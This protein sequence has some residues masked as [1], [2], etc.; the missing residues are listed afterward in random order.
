[1]TDV[2]S[3]K[4]PVSDRIFDTGLQS[5][6]YGTYP[7]RIHTG[8]NLTSKMFDQISELKELFSA[9]SVGLFATALAVATLYVSGHSPEFLANSM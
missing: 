8:P 7:V 3:N 6:G 1:M 2:Y 9:L 4:K 5:N